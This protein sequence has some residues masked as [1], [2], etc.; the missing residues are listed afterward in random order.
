M[1]MKLLSARKGVIVVEMTLQ[2]LQSINPGDDIF[3]K[4]QSVTLSFSPAGEKVTLDA[5]ISAVTR[6]SI[7]NFHIH[8]ALAVDAPWISDLME[9]ALLSGSS[10]SLLLADQI[11]S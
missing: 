10:I 4:G 7:D 11:S 6:L 2:S 1:Q 8:L 3:A 5:Q 9:Q